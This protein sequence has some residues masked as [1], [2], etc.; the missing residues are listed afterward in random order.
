MVPFDSGHR[1]AGRRRH[2]DRPDQCYLDLGRQTVEHL[3][4][5]AGDHFATCLFRRPVVRFRRKSFTFQFDVLRVAAGCSSP[6]V[7]EGS[8]AQ[9]SR[10]VVEPLLDSRATAPPPRATLN[11]H[12]ARNS[13]D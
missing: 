7:K 12:D 6:T 10:Y 8:V 5:I 11:E 3:D 1:C 4:E 2:S 9:S 13:N